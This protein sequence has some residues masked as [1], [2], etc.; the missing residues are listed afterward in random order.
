MSV[1]ELK[2]KLKLRSLRHDDERRVRNSARHLLLLTR[3][4]QLQHLSLHS[5]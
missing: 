3:C 2:L 4:R 1:L 5:L